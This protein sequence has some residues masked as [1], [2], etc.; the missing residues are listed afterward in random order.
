MANTSMHSHN[1]PCSPTTSQSSLQPR[2]P[3]CH[4]PQPSTLPQMLA[5]PPS[6]PL[7]AAFPPLPV[8]IHS[9]APL[10][11]SWPPTPLPKVC[12]F[13]TPR[14]SLPSYAHTARPLQKL[15]VTILLSLTESKTP[16]S[17]KI[18]VPNV[19]YHSGQQEDLS[20]GSTSELQG[21]WPS[22]EAGFTILWLHK[23]KNIS[24]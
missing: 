11:R 2:L 17:L 9:P 20:T 7:P 16:S 14:C 8:A 23:N 15:S 3:V 1:G 22:G 10:L 18:S 6:T 4:P 13:L 19:E 5:L 12:C 21:T 24:P